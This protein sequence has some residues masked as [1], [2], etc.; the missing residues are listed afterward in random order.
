ML[1]SNEK[2]ILRSQLQEILP[3]GSSFDFEGFRSVLTDTEQRYILPLIGESLYERLTV[4]SLEKERKMCRKAIANIAVYENF[5][6]LNTKILPGGFTRLTGENTG[7]LYKYQ[8]TELK[9]SF[10]RNGFDM[11]DSIVSY[12]LKNIEQFPEFKES[13]YYQS[14][15]GELIPD[16]ITFARYYKPVGHIVFNY[17]KPFIHRAEMLEL[18]EIV[19]IEELKNSILTNTLNENQVKT[20]KL[21]QPVLVN[22]AVAYAIEDKGIN[23]TDSGVW[24]ENHIAG[25]GLKEQSP[26][27]TQAE[28][29]ANN[30]RKIAARHLEQLQ[31]HLCGCG[32]I[33]PYLRD[34]RNKKTAWL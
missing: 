16:R 25:D 34:N 22:L 10:R 13:A 14:D 8:E 31:K 32:N 6:L 2:E 27:G 23:I 3:F 5:T 11:L 33:N 1:F 4:E 26:A 7:S 24:L 19:P 18:S 12:F 15:R 29:V 9:N 20:L 21:I 28:I 17:L 30:Y